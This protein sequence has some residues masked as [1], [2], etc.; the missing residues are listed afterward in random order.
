M[1]PFYQELNFLFQRHGNTAARSGKEVSIATYHLRRDY[2]FSDFYRLRTGKL[3][4]LENGQVVSE[5]RFKL[6]SPR[7]LKQ[8]HIRALVNDWL[9]RGLS[10]AYVHNQ[11]SVLRLFAGWIGKPDVILPIEQLIADPAYHRRSQL[12]TRDRSWS[13][14][15]IDVAKKLSEIA[16]MDLRVAMVLELMWVFSLRLKEASLL[17]PHQ[18]DQKVFLDVKRGTKGGRQRAHRIM[19]P[20]ERAVLERAKGLVADPKGCLIPP[21]LNYRQWQNKVYYILKKCRLNRQQS[22]TSTHGLR[23]EGLNRLYEEITGAKSPVRGGQPG[24]ITTETDRFARAQVAETA[25]HSH[26]RVSSAYLG[27]VLR[28]QKPSTDIPDPP[29]T[30]ESANQNADA[31]PLKEAIP[32]LLKN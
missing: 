11:L 30:P 25:G 14:C 5:R 16:G 18:A 13:G 6:T 28:G 7:K 27:G 22:G 31:E 2:L 1:E 15:G 23:H 12:A 26:P 20:E 21:D 29:S 3:V 10:V 24:E 32:D 4:K 8:K 9:A 17:R 19:A